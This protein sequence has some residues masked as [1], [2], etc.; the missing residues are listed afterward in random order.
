MGII[1]PLAETFLKNEYPV[2]YYNPIMCVWSEIGLCKHD[3][4]F[5]MY[6]QIPTTKMTVWYVRT[7]Y[8]SRVNS[9]VLEK[10]YQTNPRGWFSTFQVTL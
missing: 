5:Y 9:H 10:R 1:S 8:V 3:H 6:R 2:K 4:M 7:D